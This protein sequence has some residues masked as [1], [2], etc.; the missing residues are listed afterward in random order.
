[1]RGK[2]SI[3]AL[4]NPLDGKVFYVGATRNTLQQRLS[5]HLFSSLAHGGFMI[6]R[7]NLISLIMKKKKKTRNYS[8]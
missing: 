6:K 3:Y 8:A 7:A 5:G 2:Y 4:V 1:M